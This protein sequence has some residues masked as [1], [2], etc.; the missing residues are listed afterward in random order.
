MLINCNLL[1][2]ATIIVAMAFLIGVYTYYIEYTIDII[3][4]IKYY[5]LEVLFTLMWSGVHSII[6]RQKDIGYPNKLCI[7]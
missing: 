7:K 5:L 4:D 2:L 6:Y 1:L 3:Y